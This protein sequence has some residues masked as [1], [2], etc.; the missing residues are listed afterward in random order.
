MKVLHVSHRYWPCQGGAERYIQEMSERL[1]RDGHEVTVYT[2]DA[3]DLELFWRGGRRIA[4]REEEHN[5]VR[6]RRFPVRHLPLHYLVTLGLSQVPSRKLDLLLHQPSPLVPDLQRADAADFDVVHTTSLPYNSILFAGYRLAR[7]CGARL[8]TTPH[9]HIGEPGSGRAGRMFSRPAQ[10]WLLAQSNLVIART[11]REAGFLIQR[12]IARDRVRVLACGVNPECL[13]GGDAQR[14]RARHGLLSEE[15]I[16]FYVGTRA[17]DKGTPH[18]VEAMHR[19]W[20]SGHEARLVLA[21]ASQPHFRRFWRSQPAEVRRRTLM[22]DAISETEKLDLLAAGT[23]FA[24]P[25]RSDTF[26][27]VFLEAWTYGVPVIGA[28]AGGIPD[29]ITDGDDGFLIPF[30]DVDSLAVTIGR[31]LDDPA[32]RRRLGAAGRHK[33]MTNWTWDRVFADLKSWYAP[34]TVAV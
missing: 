11:A 19:L 4:R 23:I 27:I 8:V 21:G 5:G 25:S 6:I 26:G 12:G 16:V 31:L 14:F 3:Y 18:L 10:M 29:V 7:Q 17:F 24:M 20:R 34:A 32:L 15:P 22:L 33:T 28:D 1:V 13:A 9:M 2:T 30:G